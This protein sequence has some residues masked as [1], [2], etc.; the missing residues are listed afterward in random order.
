MQRSDSPTSNKELLTTRPISPDSTSPTKVLIKSLVTDIKMIEPIETRKFDIE[1][2]S[3]DSLTMPAINPLN[4]M[5]NRLGCLEEIASTQMMRNKIDSNIITTLDDDLRGSNQNL[6]EMIQD[7][8]NKF[9]NEIKELKK[10]Y[11]YRFELQSIENKRMQEKFAVLK[12]DLN[13]TMRK[14]GV[15]LSR[16]QKLETEVFDEDPIIDG[17]SLDFMTMSIGMDGTSRPATTL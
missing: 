10:D 4:S 2:E 8:Q 17:N 1:K 5:K 3:L 14:L 9:D 13:Q 11:D 15:A 12:S 6:R 7:M 16:L